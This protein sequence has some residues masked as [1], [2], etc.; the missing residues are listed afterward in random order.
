MCAR[1]LVHLPR[2]EQRRVSARPVT[3]VRAPCSE[4]VRKPRL[5]V[6][7]G[8]REGGLREGSCERGVVARAE[9]ELVAAAHLAVLVKVVLIGTQER[10]RV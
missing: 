8:V 4:H 2:R 3:P 5:P 10:A 1:Q 7:L 6:R 9:D